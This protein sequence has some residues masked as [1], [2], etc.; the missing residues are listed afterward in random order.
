MNMRLAAISQRLQLALAMISI[1]KANVAEANMVRQ[2]CLENK[3][4]A[5]QQSIAVSMI[6]GPH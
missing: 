2:R 4:V 6:A 5:Q 1:Q 3:N